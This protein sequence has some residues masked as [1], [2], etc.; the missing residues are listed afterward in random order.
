MR[1]A[2]KAAFVAER[3]EWLSEHPGRKA[4]DFDM[5]K[6]V[7]RDWR[8]ARAAKADKIM[9]AAFLRDHPGRFSEKAARAGIW[10]GHC[11]SICVNSIILILA[12]KPERNTSLN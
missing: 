11:P 4:R 10:R 1:D 3:K 2:L 6:A 5:R 8:K 7:C 12:L 9:R